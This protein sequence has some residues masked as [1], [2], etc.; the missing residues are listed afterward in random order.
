MKYLLDTSVIIDHIRG[1]YAIGRDFIG[2]GAA[3]S[4]ITYGELFYGAYKSTNPQKAIGIITATVAQFSLTI[5]TLTE[6][7][8]TIYAKLKANLETKGR[9]LD[10][11]DLLIAATA[12]HHSLILLTRNRKHFDRIPDLLLYERHL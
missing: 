10:D 4:I 8:M 12:L 3:A 1:K 2:D 9:R 5:Y 7:I 6:P 11:L